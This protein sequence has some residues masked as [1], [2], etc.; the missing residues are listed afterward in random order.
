MLKFFV[1]HCTDEQ[2]QLDDRSCGC[3]CRRHDSCM[4]NSRLSQ[5]QSLA[6]VCLS[7]KIIGHISGMLCNS[8][9]RAHYGWVIPRVCRQQQSRDD[10]HQQ[11]WA[12]KYNRYYGR[13]HKDESVH[14]NRKHVALWLSLIYVWLRW[15]KSTTMHCNHIVH[16]EKLLACHCRSL[17]GI[18]HRGQQWRSSAMYGACSSS[19]VSH[20][21]WSSHD[22]KK[23]KGCCTRMGQVCIIHLQ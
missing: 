18:S 16:S 20:L 12:S 4:L 3:C 6:W 15:H 5:F 8:Y 23:G 11:S 7:V 2:L 22:W 14:H 13:H 1:G 21:A 10:S 19:I 9:A 17:W